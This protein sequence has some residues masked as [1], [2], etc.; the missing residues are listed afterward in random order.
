M[1]GI[2][3]SLS[4]Y[5]GN[6]QKIDA[7]LNLLHHRGPDDSGV[8]YDD[9]IQ[10]GHTRLSILDLSK[11]GHQ[12]MAS[13]C[14]RYWITYNGEIYNFIELRK[15]LIQLGHAF[16][17]KS[18]TEVLMAAYVQWGNSC[19]ENLLGMFAFAIWDRKEKSLFLAR[20]RIG[21]KPLYYWLD[22]NR[23]VFSSE[24]KSLIPLLPAVPHLS[25]EAIDSYFHYQFIPE[26]KTALQGIHK[27]P[28]AHLMEIK[29][30]K[31]Y[32]HP[33]RYWSIENVPPVSGDP[34]ELIRLELERSID[35][36]LRSDVPVGIALSGGIDSGVIAALAASKT[37][38]PIKAFCIG[39]PGRPPYDER[40]K[41]EKLAKLY[42]I[43]FIDLELQ[44]KNFVG[45]FPKLV[46]DLDEPIAD[47]AAY[48]HYAVMKLAADHG[49][50]VMLSG[51]GGDELFW[52]Y[53]WLI[54]AKSQTNLKRELVEKNSK[55]TKIISE[56]LEGVAFGEIYQKILKSPVVPKLIREVLFNGVKLVEM[57]VHKPDQLVFYNLVPDFQRAIGIT[58]KLYTPDFSKKVPHRNPY[59]PFANALRSVQDS[60]GINIQIC[61]LLFETWLVSNCL[62]LGDRVSMTSSVET[63]FPFLDYKLIETVMGIMRNMP[64][65]GF[66]RK[67]L[68]KKAIIDILPSEFINRPKQGFRPPVE[69]WMTAIIHKHIHQIRNGHLVSNNIISLKYLNKMLKNIDNFSPYSFMLYKMIILEIW[70]NDVVVNNYIYH[71]NKTRMSN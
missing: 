3:G 4:K 29:C 7:P 55:I 62:S 67:I 24:L 51:I 31:W 26:P 22:D 49:I 45:N 36:T 30:G 53:D 50:K 68:F 32:A 8:Y 17:S 12:P 34:S 21:E 70:Y 19:V 35:L 28:S 44:T 40:N 48:G 46:A 10:L 14:G 43:P 6:H 27:L 63:R 13:N 5:P 41:A 71:K 20:D 33:K 25:P 66:E 59:S 15:E 65:G 60:N 9:Y 37:S 54:R 42:A 52:G 69:E 23:F 2:I 16:K 61:K 64:D 58:S 38:S 56:L 1:C 11:K 47:I 39:Y 57:S 18:D